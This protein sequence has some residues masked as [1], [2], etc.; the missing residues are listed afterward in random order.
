M[1]LDGLVL[2]TQN[3]QRLSQIHQFAI[4]IGWKHVWNSTLPSTVPRVI[5]LEA[6]MAKD[7]NA[8]PTRK[9]ERAWSEKD[10]ETVRSSL[11]EDLQELTEDIAAAE[12]QAVA[13]AAGMGDTSDDQA[14]A[15]SYMVEREYQLGIIENSKE[16]LLQVQDAIGRLTRGEYGICDNCK[17][18]IGKARLLAYPRATQCVECK[19]AEEAQA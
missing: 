5:D 19:K 11:S 4:Q 16:Q 10:V 7:V 15:G 1:N 17:Q 2:W 18:P 8:L 12:E 3:D 6:L 9:G 14:E 13:I